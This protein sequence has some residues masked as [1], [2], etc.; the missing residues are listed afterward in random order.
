[1]QFIAKHLAFGQYE[2]HELSILIHMPRALFPRDN[3]P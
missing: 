2:T 3:A 1:M